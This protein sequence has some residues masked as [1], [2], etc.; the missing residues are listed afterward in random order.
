LRP[1]NQL[2]A[3]FAGPGADATLSLATRLA[4]SAMVAVGRRNNAATAVGHTR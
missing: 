3:G 1:Q 4:V 2:C